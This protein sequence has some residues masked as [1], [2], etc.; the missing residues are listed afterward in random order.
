MNSKENKYNDDPVCYCSNC[1]S[2]SI[3]KL[4]NSEIEACVECG[5]TDFEI[6]DIFS[7]EKLYVEKY[8][9]AFVEIK[10][11]ELLDLNENSEDEVK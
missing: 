6:T 1:L 11:N 7:W 8:N 9:T 5:N 2:L 10:E 4:K 3:K